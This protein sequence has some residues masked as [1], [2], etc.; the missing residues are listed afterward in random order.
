MISH[1][2]TWKQFGERCLCIGGFLGVCFFVFVKF[3]SVENQ[4][5]IRGKFGLL[6]RVVPI[7]YRKKEF[8][9]LIE[10][11]IWLVFVCIFGF[12]SCIGVCSEP[13]NS[14]PTFVG[15]IFMSKHL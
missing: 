14:D 12:A 4:K 11:G 5:K 10:H 13:I 15:E 9:F 3:W 2:D 7:F 1:V 8:C 6:P